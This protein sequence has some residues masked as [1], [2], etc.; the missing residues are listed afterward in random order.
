MKK[1]ATL[2]VLFFALSNC[3][4]QEV[5]F[6]TGSNFTK[7]SFKSSNGTMLT[8]LQ[9]GTGT[10]YEI[11]FSMPF[12]NDKFSYSLGMSLNEYNAVAGSP[13]NS[14]K[15]DTKY[16]G[17]QGALNFTFCKINNFQFVARGG[18]SLSTIIYGKQTLNT[19]VYDLKKQDEFSNLLVIPFAGILTKYKLKDYGYLS[20][21]YGISKSIS[22]FNIS[23]EKLSFTTNQITFGVHFNI[24]KKE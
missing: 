2:L 14:Y 15:W 3:Y 12:K 23:D 13:S 11:G 10:N 18:V 8:R 6:S 9:S 7:Y 21:G 20:L 1:L 17:L 24:D 22:P 19:Y 5:Y 16:I 4:S